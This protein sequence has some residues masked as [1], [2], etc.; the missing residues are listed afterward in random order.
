MLRVLN[1]ALPKKYIS[2]TSIPDF[3]DNPQALF[4]YMVKSG[5]L[6]GKTV[7]WHILNED[8]RGKII[9]WLKK[10]YLS[11]DCKVVLAKKYSIKSIWLFMLSNIIVDSHGFY[12]FKSKKQLEVELWHGMPLKRIGYLLHGTPPQQK[13]RKGRFFSVTADIFKTPFSKAFWADESLIHVDG[14][15]R[16]DYLFDP[17]EDYLGMKQFYIYLPTFRKSNLNSN[18]SE[19]DCDYDENVF[20]N[21]TNDEWKRVDKVL[22][23]T[24][25]YMLVKPHPQDSVRNMGFIKD[26]KNIVLINDNDLLEKKMHL[27]RLLGASCG[28][29]TDYSSVFIDY[30][31]TDKP[32]AFFI[33]DY[34][35]YKNSRGFVF[36]NPEDTMAGK[37]CRNSEDLIDFLYRPVNDSDRYKTIKEKLNFVTDGSSRRRIFED[38]MS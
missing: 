15:P 19:F 7:V 33:P 24:G 16:N 4:D 34:E 2:F 8:N 18:L 38:L 36:D 6:K 22:A 30:M 23:E 31:L 37:I 29:I 12:D 25:R 13:I 20:L 11:H 26:C 9:N 1:S 21:L 3:A 17:V 35:E 14:Q 27:Y 28:L 5:S 32:I 10:D